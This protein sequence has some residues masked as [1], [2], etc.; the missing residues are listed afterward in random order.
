LEPAQG[1]L[2]PVTKCAVAS[3]LLFCKEMV[4]S[5]H[6]EKGTDIFSDVI[7]ITPAMC[8]PWG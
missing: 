2:Y 7:I 3:L 4:V 8:P 6:M 5:K 1:P